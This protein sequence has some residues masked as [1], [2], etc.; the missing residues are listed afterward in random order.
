MRRWIP[1]FCLCGLA[2]LALRPLWWQPA[3][4]LFLDDGY[5]HLFRVFEFDRV[6]REG[7]VYPRW[8]PDLAYG[9]GYPIFNFY[10]PLAY[11][12]TETLHLFGLSIP[13]AVQA[14]FAVIVCVG[15]AGAYHL[16]VEVYGDGETEKQAR[17]R[18]H[19][20]L[21]TA[22]GYVFFPYFLLDLYVRGAIAESLAAAIL[23]FLMWSFRRVLKGPRLAE[24]LL[25]AIF[26]ASLVLSH[27]LTALFSAPLLSLYVAWEWIHLPS[28]RRVKGLLALS[29]AVLLGA[30]LAAVYWVPLIAEMPLVNVSREAKQL[31]IIVQ[32]SILG[33]KDV[34]QLS[35]PYQYHEAPFPLGLIPTSLAAISLLWALVSRRVPARRLVIFFGILA[36]LATLLLTEVTLGIWLSIPVMMTLQFPWRLSVLIGLCAAVLIG[37]LPGAAAQRRAKLGPLPTRLVCSAGIAVLLIWAG[38]ANLAPQRLDYPRGEI[39]LGQLARFEVNSR[40]IGLG[41]MD[42]YLP[43]TVK[44]LPRQLESKFDV[45]ATPDIELEQYGTA[46]RAMTVNASAQVA[47]SLHSFYFPDWRVTIDGQPATAA[48]STAMGLLT[49]DVPAGEHRIVFESVDTV[50]RQIGWLLSGLGWLVLLAL[51]ALVAARRN[52]TAVAPALAALALLSPFAIP[53]GLAVVSSPTALLP[54]RVDVSPELNLIGLRIEDAQLSSNVWRVHGAPSMLNLQVIWHVK[55]QLQDAPLTWQ[56]VDNAGQVSCR[57]EQL[58]RYAAGLAGTWVPNEIVPDYYDLP[59]TPGMPPGRYFLQLVAGGE[60]YPVGVIELPKGSAPAWSAPTIGQR[61]DAQ[62]GDRIRLLG[63]T[64]PVIAQPGSNL[65][66]TLFWQATRDVPEDYTVFVHLLDDEQRLV[67]QNDGLTHNGFLPTTLWS[68]GAVIPDERNIVLPRDLQPGLY[69]L[70][71]GLYRFDN[72]ERLPVTTLSGPSPDDQIALG[73]IKVPMQAQG[74]PE[75]LVNSSLG[76]RIRLAGFDLV[77]R[78]SSGS[79]RRRSDWASPSRVTMMPGQTMSLTLYWQAVAPVVSDYKVF[80]H[81]VDEGGNVVAQQDQMPG[82]NRY[83]TRIWDAGEKVVDSYRLTLDLPIGNYTIAAGMYD[84]TSGER[85]VA[86]DANGKELPDREI[87]VGRLEIVESE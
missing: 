72:L 37:I 1:L 12:L 48:P 71:A 76:E 25:A 14:A 46:Q 68:V 70:V 10:P 52:G 62:A 87:V 58:P 83:P 35:I 50:P 4:Y 78:D 81:I 77:S 27:N 26:S 24:L 17:D 73:T 75:H 49:V 86:R 23:P 51:I 56:L 18:Q 54:T 30:A 33:L 60:L 3:P 7:V 64:A 9:Y 69:Y 5:L 43:L 28:G 16:G 66:L 55:R 41:T 11:Y 22:C 67:A 57:R 20:G 59:L 36:V 44:F 19:A 31:A 63:Y 65:P 13:A 45:P 21:L 47:L 42:E 40:N 29:G 82:Q 15:L 34:L 79:V 80:V 85:L 61:V 2:V 39:T 38:L 6:L 84:A 53:T 8:A 74:S 32:Y